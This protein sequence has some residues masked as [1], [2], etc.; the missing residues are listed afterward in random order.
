RRAH[1][2][3]SGSRAHT[4]SAAVPGI[5]WNPMRIR[6]ISSGERARTLTAPWDG[7]TSSLLAP[8]AGQVSFVN[9]AQRKLLWVNMATNQA[10]R[11][12]LLDCAGLGRIVLD[13]GGRWSVSRAEEDGN[14]TILRLH[15]LTSGKEH[16]RL[17]L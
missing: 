17:A 10:V 7:R 12:T 8:D 5:C 2:P 13:R 11:E 14:D 6:D 4:P 9:W 15:D 3:I 16:A 1:L